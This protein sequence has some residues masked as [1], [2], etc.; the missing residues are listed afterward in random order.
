MQKAVQAKGNGPK[1][2]AG[3]GT[4]T[5]TISPD[6]LELYKMQIALAV[7]QNWVFSDIMAGLDQNLEVKVFVKVLKSGEIRDIDYETRS[8][9]KYLDESAKKAIR[10]SNPLP[11]LPKGLWPSYEFVLGF[12]PKG[13]K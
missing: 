7:R 8:G 4:G 6:I 11:Q 5:G 2:G 1:K 3:V 10:R 9:N 12:T 13:L